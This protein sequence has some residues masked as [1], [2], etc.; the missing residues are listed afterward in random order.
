MHVPQPPRIGD[1]VENQ[2]V[3][4]K[5]PQ[6]FGELHASSFLKA[7]VPFNII[8][9]QATCKAGNFKSGLHNYGRR[10]GLVGNSEV[11][12]TCGPYNVGK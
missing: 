12:K 11:L 7:L 1:V 8:L 5:L 4:K 3:G 6:A 9:Q 2:Q 10:V